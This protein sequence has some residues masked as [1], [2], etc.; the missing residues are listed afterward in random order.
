M[1]D[2]KLELHDIH[3]TNE[4]WM[5]CGYVFYYIKVFIMNYIWIKALKIWFK[6]WRQID[7]FLMKGRGQ[8]LQSIFIT[9]TCLIDEEIQIF[10]A[11]PP[12]DQIRH[13]I[14]ES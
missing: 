13:L 9:L 7:I 8:G 1:Y 2:M 10:S 14:Q 12:I 6:A 5:L 3:S 4:Q 11:N